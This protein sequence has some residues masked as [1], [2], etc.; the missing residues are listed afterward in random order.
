MQKTT[1]SKLSKRLLQYGAL[2][3]SALGAVDASGQ[4]VYTD[5][6][7]DEV[8]IVG[9]EFIVDMTGGGTEFTVNNPDALTNGNAAIIFPSSGGAFVGV[10]AGGFE[11]PALLAAG[12]VIDG[13]AGF[14][15]VGERGDLNYYGCAYANS[16]WCGD[17]NDGYLGVTFTFS[18]NTHYGWI[19]LDTDV[20]GTNEI[21]VKDFAYNS[22]ADEAIEAGQTLGLEESSINNIRIVTLNNSITMHNLPENTNFNLFSTSGQSVLKGSTNG[23]T[24]V[25]EA[26]SMATGVYVLELNDI[27]TNAVIRKKI[28]L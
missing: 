3:A 15:A 10:T 9:E 14:T 5:V 27:A 16:E 20:G 6:N 18:G 25:V 21:V 23:S 2:S 24:Y 28:V 22:V 11:Y 1:S 26:Y 13:T 17:V 4:I 7:P 8:L 19:R 12:E